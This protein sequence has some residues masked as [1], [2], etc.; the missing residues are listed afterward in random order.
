MRRDQL[1]VAVAGAT[2]AVGRTTLAILEERG[3]PVGRLLPLASERS[4]GKRIPFKGEEISVRKLTE[5]AFAGVDLAF[6]A[7]GASCSRAFI[8]AAMAA[9]AVVIDKSSAFRQDPEVPLV[10]PEVNPHALRRHKGLIATPN[11]S[12]IQLVVALQPLHEAARIKRVVVSTYQSVAGAGQQGIAELRRQAWQVLN[13][14]EVSPE[15][16]PHPIAFN[17][18]PQIDAFLENGYT[19]EEMKMTWETQKIMEDES[20]SVSATTVRVPVFYGHS[21]SV[22]LETE[23]KLSAREAQEILA[24]APG[25]VVVDEPREHRYPMAIH[26]A[27]QDP[28]FVGR[29][30]EDLSAEKALHLWI[31]AD[32]LRKGAALNAVQIAELLI[33]PSG[34]MEE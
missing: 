12:T 16:F 11:C 34:L 5:K 30:R 17:C 26:C 4:E 20:I 7:A 27:G 15:V 1:T 8:P 24:R 32:S 29:I 31:V 14:Q 19:K 9:G 18:L 6:F 33:H 3:F 13:G 2:G 25:V 28:V 23:R 10:V 21:E 22:N